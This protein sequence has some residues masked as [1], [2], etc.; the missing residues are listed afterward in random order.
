MICFIWF[1]ILYIHPCCC[2]WQNF[3]LFYGWVMLFNCGVGEDSWES[4]GQ[5][6][7]PSSPFWRRSALGFLWK[8][9]MLTL[10]LQYFGHLMRRADSF[11]KTLMLG[12]IG[13][14]RR[15][16]RPD[17]MAG[18]HHWLDG[19]E[20]ELTPGLGDGQGDLAC[21]DSWGRKE[22]YT[23]E[24]LNW[25]EVRSGWSI[26]TGLSSF[27]KPLYCLKILEV[28]LIFL[29]GCHHCSQ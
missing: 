15:R 13:G 29:Q 25:T 8:E 23:T 26:V 3:I 27:R 6:G 16:G 2:K 18:W 11:E 20:S 7:D 21:C 28:L 1:N 22:S 24:R 4:L 19:R 10:K 5:Q 17:E 12:G 9:L 14:R